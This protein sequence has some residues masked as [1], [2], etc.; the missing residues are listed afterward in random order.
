MHS[1]LKKTPDP[2]QN[3]TQFRRHLFMFTSMHVTFGAIIIMW[4]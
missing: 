4:P 1:F 3:L 2:E